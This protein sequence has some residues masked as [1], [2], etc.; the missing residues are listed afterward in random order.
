M[1]SAVVFSDS[2]TFSFENH[3]VANNY[4]WLANKK[5]TSFV[6][7]RFNGSTF[8]HSS[9]IAVTVLEI[10]FG[11]VNFP[12]FILVNKPFSVIPSNG[13]ESVRDLNRQT[14]RLQISVFLPS[15]GF[16]LVYLQK[17]TSARFQGPYKLASHRKFSAYYPLASRLQTQSQ[18]I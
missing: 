15:Y 9:Y 17:I 10:H 1:L 13:K 16:L 6:E 11:T 12:Y 8:K 14:P 18:S 5:I 2:V 4:F 3:S 7:I